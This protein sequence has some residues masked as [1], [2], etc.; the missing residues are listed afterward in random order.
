MENHSNIFSVLSRFNYILQNVR[1]CNIGL[2]AS[3]MNPFDT[4]A[5]NGMQC[6]VVIAFYY[7]ETL[8]IFYRTT[9]CFQYTL[10]LVMKFPNL[11]LSLM[12]CSYLIKQ[13]FCCSCDEPNSIL[14]YMELQLLQL[15]LNQYV[16]SSEVN[17]FISSLQSGPL[18]TKN[19]FSSYI[20]K[21]C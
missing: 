8:I 7:F 15:Y 4:R 11:Q 3:R 16:S 20:K 13:T 18:D 17:L 21:Q 10:E 5:T 19:Y 6:H 9:F 12:K 2:R 1:T 14:R